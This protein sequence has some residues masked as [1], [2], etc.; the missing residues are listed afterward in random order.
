MD[1][2]ATPLLAMLASFSAGAADVVAQPDWQR[3]FEARGV[4]GTFVLFEP[5]SDRYLVL[6]LPRARRGFLPAS[7][8]KIVNALVGLEVGSVTDENEVFHWDGKPKM[9]AAWERDH[10]LVSGMRESV[11]WMFQ[12]IA[13]RTGKQRMR[14]WLDKLQYGNADIRG[15]IDLFWLQGNLRVSAME[16]VDF[17]RRLAEGALP[18]SQRSQ[19][20]V[21]QALVAERGC[22]DTL[23]A[24]TG[25]TGA[26]KD[27]VHWWIGWIDRQGR[28]L[29]Y[30]AMNLTP[31]AKTRH[32]DRFAIA[33]DILREAGYRIPA[34]MNDCTNWRWKS[35]NATSKGP[36][37]MR[38]AAVTTDQSMP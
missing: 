6:D 32:D 25:T 13:R 22:G 36:E 1:R 35:R 16:Q 29:V 11:V 38:V 28:P 31:S 30:F 33:A 5:A 27:P 9:R 10:T 21:R 18:M 26:V 4:R 12:E 17:L 19:R 34:R 3:H 24:K 37:V 15:G 8:F 14:E 7:T 2:I 23:Y 20:L